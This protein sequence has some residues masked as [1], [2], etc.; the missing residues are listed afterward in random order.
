MAARRASKRWRRETVRRGKQ[1][2]DFWWCEVRGAKPGPT[3]GVVAGQHGMEPTGPA[4]LAAFLHDLDPEQVRGTLRAVPMAYVEALR[5]GYECDLSP[6][7]AA[8]ARDHAM[9]WGACPFGLNRQRC[10]RNL[11]RVWP[12]KPDGTLHQRLAAALWARLFED[13]QFVI[14]FHCWSDSGPPGTI[15]YTDEA[16]AFGRAFGIPFLHRY[17][18]DDHPGML[19]LAA[20]RADKVAITVE[21]TPQ[22]RITP[23]GAHATRK[24]LTNAMRHLGMLAGRPSVPRTQYLI[25]Y[26]PGD[27]RPIHLPWDAV[28]IPATPPAVWCRK[29]D[30]IGT[31]VRLDRPRTVRE[32]KA[33]C[34]GLLVGTPQRA[35]VREGESALVFYRA[36]V[37]R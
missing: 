33:P 7:A 37:L 28:V 18:L 16:L 14:D 34:A 29:G 9:N 17:P 25:E 15:A 20:L 10:G 6:A 12:G 11:N 30:V 31:A 26:G 5:G 35:V 24:G 23:D 32:L 3:L 8:H 21:L 4:A 1:E 19:A 36:K 22:V 2:R 13:A 27:R